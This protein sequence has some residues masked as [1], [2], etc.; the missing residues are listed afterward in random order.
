MAGKFPNLA[1]N[2]NMQIQKAKEIPNRINLRKS[3]PRL[4]I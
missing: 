4:V 3:M 2:I 1:T